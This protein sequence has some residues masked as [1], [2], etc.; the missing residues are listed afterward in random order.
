MSRIGISAVGTR[1]LPRPSSE[2]FR[3]LR[4]GIRNVW[5]YDNQEF[6]LADGWLILRGPNTAGKS[7]A[8]ELLLPFVLDGETRPERLDPF[9]GRS[10]TMYWN[11]IDFDESRRSEIG[12]C[13]LEFGRVDAEGQEHFVTCIVGMRATRG[14]DRR[15]D[16]WFAVTPQRIGADLDLVGADSRLLTPDRLKQALE[17]RGRYSTNA[18]DHRSAVDQ[19]LFG[20]GHERFEGLL[21]L[22]LQLRRPK[23]SEKLDVAKLAGILSEALPPLER[24]RLELLAQGFARL[25]A[26]ASELEVL[27]RA[28]IEL[29]TFLDAYRHYARVQTRLRAKA[30]TSAQYEFDN[31]ARM[32]RQQREALKGA[33]DELTNVDRRR[34]E[35]DREDARLSGHLKGLDLSKVHHLD[36]VEGRAEEAERAADANAGRASRDEALAS[37]AEAESARALREAEAAAARR[38][39]LVGELEELSSDAGLA[40]VVEAHRPQLLADPR[41]ARRALEAG[42]DRRTGLI[43]ELQTVAAVERRVQGEVQAADDRAAEVERLRQDAETLTRQAAEV[44]DRAASGFAAAVELW[45]ASSTP[46]VRARLPMPDDLGRQALD[47]VLAAGAE[48]T[49]ARGIARKL[50]GPAREALGAERAAALAELRRLE[51]DRAALLARREAIAAERDDAPGRIPGRPELRSDGCA[52]LWRCVE[53]RPSLAPVER[54]AL[55][56][57]LEAAGLLDALVTPEGR[58]L[59]A[60]TL[61]TV[62]AGPPMA[63]I[64]LAAWLVPDPAAPLPAAAVARVLAA[65]GAGPSGPGEAWVGLDGSWANGVLSGRWAKAEAE[66]VG[67]SARAAAR[68]RRIAEIDRQLASVASV[69]DEARAATT[70]L[71][72]LERQVVETE[73]QFPTPMALRDA[74]RDEERARRDLARLAAEAAQAL[75]VLAAARARLE[76]AAAAL[77]RAETAAGCRASQVDAVLAALATWRTRLAETVLEVEGAA[78]QWRAAEEA[79][80]R[81]RAGRQVAETSAAG[82]RRDRE[83]ADRCRGEANE[84]RQTVGADVQAILARKAE[85][86]AA[87]AAVRKELAKL[88]GLRDTVRDRFTQAQ[89]RLSVTEQARRQREQERAERLEGLAVLTATELGPLALGPIDPQRDL[90]QVTTGVAFA[91]SAAERLEAVPA[92][93]RAQDLANNRLHASFGDLRARLGS[94]FDPHLDSRDGVSLC[95]AKLNGASVGAIDLAGALNEQIQRRRETLSADEREVIEQHLLA[96]VGNHLGDR[97]HA[98]WTHLRRMNDQLA[99]HG[100]RSGVTLHLDWEP[101]PDAGSGATEALKLLRNQVHLLDA[102]ERATLAAFL[103]D[104]VRAARED[105]EGADAVERMA[106]AL[107]YRR[108]H[109]FVVIRRTNRREERFTSRT[110]GHGSGGEQAKLAHLPLFAATAG[111]YAS[112]APTCPRLLVLDEAFVGIDDEQRADCMGMLVEL[113]L[114]LVLTNYNEWGCYPQ[115][116][117]VAIYHLERTEGELGVAALRFVWDGRSRREDD[118][119]LES[120]EPPPEGLFAQGFESAAEDLLGED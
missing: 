108:W 8:L 104:R 46:E 88:A 37:R 2:R 14:A 47:A 27:E 11:L 74:L 75:E 22:L 77:A 114:D 13:W 59:D 6:W 97:V 99:Q 62:V 9:G 83:E 69:I 86:E 111:Y 95:F 91:R 55:E 17:G 115:V 25:D 100:T 117:S 101:N 34:A 16:P 80:E 76:Q 107:D 42:A 66:F 3:P 26:E 67:A 49:A 56:A 106:S 103:A 31:V 53:F 96:E 70:T 119:F 38:D 35:L 109:R 113:G 19:A 21:H 61:D 116:P 28:R 71:A 30:V 63:G 40:D 29:E 20:L 33:E 45:A 85:L 39:G 118:P 82:A 24:G 94:D 41:A 64:A 1:G 51:S 48:D 7:K 50:C 32:E 18:R 102:R 12:Y 65:V 89:T 79:D 57:A 5:E 87:F 84:L 54:A 105:A 23:L 72:D 10:K 58:L 44:L 92:E 78:R 81:A 43:R 36:L 112:A 15:V 93:P 60:E 68:A 98:A 73:R 120:L 4:A 110:Q 52:G 90:T